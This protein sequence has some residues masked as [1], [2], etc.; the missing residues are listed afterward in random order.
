MSVLGTSWFVCV[1]ICLGKY[2]R[3]CVCLYQLWQELGK[4]LGAPPTVPSVDSFVDSVM[5]RGASVAI[6]TPAQP[7][8]RQTHTLSEKTTSNSAFKRLQCIAGV[9]FASSSWFSTV[10]SYNLNDKLHWQPEG[11]RSAFG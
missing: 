4:P 7:R 9:Q 11:Q 10:V 5:V 1:C 6:L 2:V 3:K 8:G